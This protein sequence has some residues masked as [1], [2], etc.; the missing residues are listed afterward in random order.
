M[1][2]TKTTLEIFQF[3]CLW[4]SHS[5]PCWKIRQLWLYF[6]MVVY[7][8]IYFEAWID[9]E[10][11]GLQNNT[12]ELYFILGWA[13][14]KL[15]WKFSSFHASDIHTHSLLK[16]L[17]ISE[18]SFPNSKH[19]SALSNIKYKYALLFLSQLYYLFML[20]NIFFSLNTNVRS[21]QQSRIAC[22]SLTV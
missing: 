2:K 17:W 10:Y 14:R 5:L 12:R 4:Y 18:P 13:K 20:Q 1:S 8:R 19:S 11:N 6:T 22:S 21:L 15:L 16:N 3:P 9:N 7:R